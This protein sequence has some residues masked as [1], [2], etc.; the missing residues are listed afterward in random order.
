M[1]MDGNVPR[2]VPMSQNTANLL[3]LVRFL[4]WDSAVLNVPNVPKPLQPPKSGVFVLMGAT[5]GRM[6][7]PAAMP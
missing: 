2:G 5:G 6:P 7:L 1:G 4:L 3:V